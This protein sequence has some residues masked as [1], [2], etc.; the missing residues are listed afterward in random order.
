MSARYTLFQDD[1]TLD[2]SV[3]SRLSQECG[4]WQIVRAADAQ[5]ARDIMNRR[6]S[7]SQGLTA[8]SHLN[9]LVKQA[10]RPLD[11]RLTRSEVPTGTNTLP[12]EKSA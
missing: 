4:P 11:Q 10:E 12:Q 7:L 5:L 6:F 3:L 8:L 1:G 2:V 9:W